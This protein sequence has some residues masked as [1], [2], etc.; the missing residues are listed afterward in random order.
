VAAIREGATA[1]T[2]AEQYPALSLADIYTALG[3]YLRH[4]MEVDAYLEG[5]HKQAAQ[6]RLENE[7]RCN[8]IGIRDRLLVRRKSQG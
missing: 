3:N 5:R 4:Q 8:P 7:A 6:V 2:I 1:E